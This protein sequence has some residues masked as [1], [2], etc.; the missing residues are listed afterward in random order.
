LN[1]RDD[2]TSH[3]VTLVK[4]SWPCF[5]V[6]VPLANTVGGTVESDVIHTA[7]LS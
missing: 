3:D 6:P 4:P 1:L 2:V 7:G 5:D